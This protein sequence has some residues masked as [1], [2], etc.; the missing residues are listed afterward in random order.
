MSY[1]LIKYY[2]EVGVYDLTDMVKCVE[3][4]YIT[5]EQFHSITGYDYNGLKNL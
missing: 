1:D 5:K 4:N 2:F 3:K